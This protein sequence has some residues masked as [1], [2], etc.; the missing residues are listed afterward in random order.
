MLGAWPIFGIIVVLFFGLVALALPFVESDPYWQSFRFLLAVSR[1]WVAIVATITLG[2][3]GLIAWQGTFA[4][5]TRLVVYSA[6][7][8]PTFGVGLLFLGKAGSNVKKLLAVIRTDESATGTVPDGHS[9]ISERAAH[10][11][12][13]SA[14]I[15]GR[16]A[17]AWEWEFY[18]RNWAYGFG[19]VQWTPLDE[20]TGGV[21]FTLHDGT[22][23][24][25]VDPRETELNLTKRGLIECDPATPPGRASKITDLDVRGDQFR[26]VERV[27]RPGK[28]VTVIGQSTDGSFV[29]EMVAEG[30]RWAPHAMCGYHVFKYGAAGV[31]ISLFSV[32]LLAS[33]FGTL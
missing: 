25:R 16:S 26:F 7:L 6:I 1:R 10:D 28:Q 31:A 9:V 14:P 32:L 24:I 30:G 2:M 21:P 11:D 15:T 5:D 17:V 27:L 8:G 22:N 23:E 3:L 33:A 19:P 13:P 18:S 12:P 20:G 4:P 29:P